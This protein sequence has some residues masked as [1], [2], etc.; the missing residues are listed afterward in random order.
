MA[1]DFDSETAQLVKRFCGG[2]AAATGE[3]L[4]VFGPPLRAFL[5]R[6]FGDPISGEVEQIALDAVEEAR[7]CGAKFEPSRGSFFGWLSGIARHLAVKYFETI[8][9]DGQLVE[10]PTSPDC[11]SQ[12]VDA[13][14]G[15]RCAGFSAKSR[16]ACL[17]QIVD[18]RGGEV[19]AAER[20]GSAERDSLVHRALGAL[21]EVQRQVL[22][23]DACARDALSSRQLGDELGV[24]DST[25]RCARQRGKEA[26]RS[27]LLDL[28]IEAF[29][30]CNTSGQYTNRGPESSRASEGDSNP[31]T[32]NGELIVACGR[33]SFQGGDGLGP[34]PQES[35]ERISGESA[36]SEVDS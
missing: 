10:L 30:L 8:G 21:N 35:G 31:G 20:P 23:A 11:L 19:Q 34:F 26:L 28:G 9:A 22:W 18:A 29:I 24:P 3:V 4:G 14:G 36:R 17:S 32:G 33:E 2:D 16:P 13:R 1:A 15:D 27:F 7:E 5:R 12:I 25:V 6:A